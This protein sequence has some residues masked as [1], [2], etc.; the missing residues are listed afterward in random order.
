MSM[1][2]LGVKFQPST[3]T[4]SHPPI[5]LSRSDCAFFNVGRPVILLGESTNTSVLPCAS[6]PRLRFGL[7]SGGSGSAP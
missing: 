1:P 5:R 3:T 7:C 6:R 2:M 4:F